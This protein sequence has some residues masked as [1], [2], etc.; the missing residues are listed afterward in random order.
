MDGI[1]KLAAFAPYL[2]NEIIEEWNPAASSA[3]SSNKN[4]TMEKNPNNPMPSSKNLIDGCGRNIED[5]PIYHAALPNG[6]RTPILKTM[7]TSVCENNC[8]YCAFRSG[9]DFRRETFRPAELADITTRLWQSGKITGL[10]LSSGIAGGGV[11]TQDKILE[12]AEV[13]RRKY[14][15]KG[16]L[17]LKI[18]PG[19][20]KAQIERAMQL[21]DRVSVNLEAPNITRLAMLAPQKT[22]LDDLLQR[23][24]WIEEIRTNQ[25]PSHT[26]K[27]KWPSSVTQFVAGGAHENDLELLQ[28]TS[29]LTHTLHLARVYF[30]GFNPVPDTP[31][32]NQPPFDPTRNL[33]LYQASFLL[34]DYGISF[35]EM[36]FEPDGNLP[37]SVNPKLAMA[38]INYA[39]RPLEINKCS[40]EELLRIPGIGLKGAQ[41]I[42][43]ARSSGKITNINQLLNLGVSVKQAAPF[44]KINGKRPTLQL[45]LW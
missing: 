45:P 2:D 44:V 7:V 13:L 15:F 5:I 30:S 33:R 8:Y 22:F 10:F 38:Q 34:R 37:L 14:H 24:K 41:I 21:A 20:E 35:E 26:W 12:S 32:D 1:E 11:R 6:R 9:R 25:S 42:M 18:M 23:L 29:Y 17:H 39:D 31:L 27:L 43:K 3:P 28:T 19:A 40:K 4:Q 36:P 16:Y